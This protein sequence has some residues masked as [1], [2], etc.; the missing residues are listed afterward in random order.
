MTVNPYVIVTFDFVAMT[1]AHR[2]STAKTD[3]IF[4][5]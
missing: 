4:G 1:R 2:S 3:L 5:H